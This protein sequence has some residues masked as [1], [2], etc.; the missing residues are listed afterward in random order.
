M[1]SESEFSQGGKT[2]LFFQVRILG[3]TERVLLQERHDARGP[4]DPRIPAH[5]APRPEKR[6]LQQTGAVGQELRGRLQRPD[7]VQPLRPPLRQRQSQGAV[8]GLEQAGSDE[9]LQGRLSDGHACVV[10]ERLVQV[11]RDRRHHVE[12]Q[13]TVG[14]GGQEEA[15]GAGKNQMNAK[16]VTLIILGVEFEII[17]LLILTF[18]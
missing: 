2:F 18:C 17:V 12:L 16:M 14:G 7:R 10:H 13:G 9:P 4:L 6:Q 1:A 5:D 8:L 15:G 11:R 3:H